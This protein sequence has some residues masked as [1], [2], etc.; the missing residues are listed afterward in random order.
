[1]LVVILV[2][3]TVPALAETIVT[4]D[5]TADTTWDLAGSPYI[6]Q[7]NI[8]VLSGATLTIDP[9]V[10]VK[11]ES[12]VRIQTSTDSPIVAVGEPGN[13]ILFTSNAPSPAPGD[14]YGIVLRHASTSELTHCTLDFG[15]YNLYVEFC[16]PSVTSCTA[17]FA[18]SAG[19]SCEDASPTFTEC[20]GTENDYAFRITGGNP[21]LTGCQISGNDDG[22]YIYGSGSNPVINYC[23]IFNNGRNMYLGGYSILP[24][25]VIDA[26]NN[27][28]GVD[29]APAI[30][31]TFF[32]ASSSVGHVEVDY[33]PW[34]GVMPVVETSWSR[35]KAI[36]R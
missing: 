20:T 5:I 27:W 13:E 35:M 33:D 8:N 7:N 29:T 9:G 22:F 19:F 26:E 25:T 4:E 21:I 10:T 16:S 18:S 3:V 34:S 14:W 31:A 15:T 36:F 30:E 1:M 11:L 23:N 6:V 12:N 32:I 24:A 28:W 2:L 17:R